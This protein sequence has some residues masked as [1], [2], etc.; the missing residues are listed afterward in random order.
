MPP[1]RAYI[2]ST[3]I[4][5]CPVPAEKQS[6]VCR[7][8]FAAPQAG[9]MMRAGDGRG[10]IVLRAVAKVGAHSSAG[11]VVARRAFVSNCVARQRA[12]S[13][14]KRPFRSY[15]VGSGGQQ[16]YPNDLW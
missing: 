12:S 4:Y 3:C 11:V 5:Y 8:G 1:A 2:L 10:R 15:A 6:F 9:G 13:Y 14:H 7:F 16:G